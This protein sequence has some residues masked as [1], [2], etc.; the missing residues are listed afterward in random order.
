V[1]H[2]F[3]LWGWPR[4][5]KE[6]YAFALR[7]FRNC[8]EPKW[9]EGAC[10]DFKLGVCSRVVLIR[11]AIP[12]DA[13]AIAEVHVA[14]WQVGYRGQ[15]P[16]VVLDALDVSSRAVFWREV[17]SASHNVFVAEV[18]SVIAGFCSLIPSRDDD[19]DNSAVAE[20]AALYLLPQHWRR[21][22]G[23]RLCLSA[24]EAAI[25]AG[26]SSVTLWVL[27]TNCVAI[28]FY[29]SLGFQRDGAV[30]SEETSGGDTLHE[31]RM[32]RRFE[33]ITSLP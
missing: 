13:D 16:D 18:G 21:G 30:K 9:A 32:R 25:R 14:T 3:A 6:G 22:G 17:L 26:F 7:H 27:S 12:A 33:G 19:A 5:E 20:I 24:F 1:Q 8:D 4:S 2:I 29:E 15:I 31:F 10:V 23:R 28:R 11:P